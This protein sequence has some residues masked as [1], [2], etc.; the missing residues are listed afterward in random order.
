LALASESRKINSQPATYPPLSYSDRC[1]T[2]KIN[3][4]TPIVPTLNKIV[5]CPTTPPFASILLFLHSVTI[6][7]T[8]TY[9]V[10]V[11]SKEP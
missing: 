9:D 2:P 8:T 6:Y 7:N 3:E 4:Q 11:V 1:N 5:D 10:L